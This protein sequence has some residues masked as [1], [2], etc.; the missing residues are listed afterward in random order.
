MRSLRTADTRRTAD[1]GRA[2]AAAGVP[3]PPWSAPADGR[4]RRADGGRC[5]RALTGATA[6][7]ATPASLAESATANDATGVPSAAADS[8]A[9]DSAAA[10][11]ACSSA[12]ARA[13]EISASASAASGACCRAR[14]VTPRGDNVT[15]V[16]QPAHLCLRC[17]RVRAHDSGPDLFVHARRALV[18]PAPPRAACTATAHLQRH[19]VQDVMVFTGRRV[20]SKQHKATEAGLCYSAER[21]NAPPQ[22]HQHA[23]AADLRCPLAPRSSP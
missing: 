11:L 5:E 8:A 4:R 1:D 23:R 10:L 22:R 6:T 18:S 13:L 7:G 14:N 19:C 2:A 15:P 20:R 16:P 3:A 9:A 12:A 21:V 17:R